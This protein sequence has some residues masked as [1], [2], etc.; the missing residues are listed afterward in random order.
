M[1]NDEQLQKLVEAGDDLKT[2]DAMAYRKI[3]ASL[4]HEP[5]LALPANFADKIV[6]RIESKSSSLAGDYFWLTAG[7]L[8]IFISTALAMFFAGVQVNLEFLSAVKPLKGLFVFA[9]IFVIAI[10]LLDKRILKTSTK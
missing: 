1:N 4:R 7:L 2:P 9:F 10:H 8:L 3:F 5:A 6:Q